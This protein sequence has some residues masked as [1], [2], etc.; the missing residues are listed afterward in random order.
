MILNKYTT[1]E[2]TPIDIEIVELVASKRQKN[3]E[4][5][6]KSGKGTAATDDK[7]LERNIIGF[8]AE[9]LFCKYYNLFPDF[10]IGNTSKLKGTDPCDAILNGRTVDVKTTTKDYPLMTP[11]Y[12]K[13]NCQIFALFY[14]EYP[15]YKFE[16]FATNKMLFKQQ[17]LLQRFTRSY[18]L[19][20]SYV[21]DK[22]HLLEYNQLLF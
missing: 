18:L 21:L 4:D 22:E 10:S 1:L 16:G 17:N 14:C 6:G 3:K 19:K 12:S 13:S 9:Y 15:K 8:G 2:L 11:Y 5:T 20:D 7:H